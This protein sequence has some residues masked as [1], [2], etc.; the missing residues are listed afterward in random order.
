MQ[1]LAIS[2]PAATQAVAPPPPPTANPFAAPPAYPQS[3]T[4]SEFDSEGIEFLRPLG[5]KGDLKPNDWLN[6]RA[7][8][9]IDSKTPPLASPVSTYASHSR[10]PSNPRISYVPPG[11][12]PP[13]P[14]PAPSQQMWAPPPH[15]P[16]YGRQPYQEPELEPKRFGPAFIYRRHGSQ[17]QL[18]QP[19]RLSKGLKIFIQMFLLFILVGMAFGA[20]FQS[21][22][23]VSCG[24]A[25][26]SDNATVSD[27]SRLERH[28]DSL[29]SL[30][31]LDDGHDE[32]DLDGV[33][34][35]AN[36]MFTG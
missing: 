35:G 25:Y 36:R 17:G 12:P 9:P 3:T 26:H 31:R 23:Q 5:D 30:A 13:V 18:G 11:P 6:E 24:G 34:A 14:V 22:R 8:Y 20:G 19:G 27:I 2:P 16:E 28:D 21:G 29:D 33:V 1:G 15:D 10:T 32:N 7:A 4:K